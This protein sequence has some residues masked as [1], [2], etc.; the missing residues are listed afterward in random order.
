MFRTQQLFSRGFRAFSTARTFRAND[1]TKS[2]LENVNKTVG[3]TLAK[4]IESAGTSGMFALA[5]G[6]VALTFLPRIGAMSVSDCIF[7]STHD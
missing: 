7:K 1:P 3:E 6:A 5:F 4:G 2:T